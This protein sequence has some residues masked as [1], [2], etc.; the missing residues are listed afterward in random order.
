MKRGT[1]WMIA[2]DFVAKINEF[3]LQKRVDKGQGLGIE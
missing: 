3:Y 2:L 1:I